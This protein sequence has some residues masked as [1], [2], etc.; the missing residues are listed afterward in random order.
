MD[1]ALQICTVFQ[2]CG[3]GI[4]KGGCSAQRI[5][6]S[7]LADGKHSKIQ[8]I[9]TK[10]PLGLSSLITFLFSDKKVT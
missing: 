9:Y 3:G 8:C 10:R 7:M 6:V 4:P 5:K 2:S 1:T